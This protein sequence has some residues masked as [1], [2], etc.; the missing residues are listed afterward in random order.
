MEE[1]EEEVL[2]SGV[3]PLGPEIQQKSS[4]EPSLVHKREKLFA[5]CARFV[6]EK[7]EFTGL[8]YLLFHMIGAT[9]SL[10]TP[11]VPLVLKRI[12]V[13]D[14]TKIFRTIFSD[15]FWTIMEVNSYC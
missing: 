6:E 4:V 12:L 11:I 10:K 14:K 5:E 7:W 8:N 15:S 9:V 13:I 2:L 3:V 1:V